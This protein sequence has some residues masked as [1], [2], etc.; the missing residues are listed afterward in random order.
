MRF[1]TP[2]IF[3]GAFLAVAIFAMG[4]L[5]SA[6]SHYLPSGEQHTEANQQSATKSEDKNREPQ[7]L[8]VPTDSVG[9]YTLVLCVFTGVLALVS[10]FQGMMLLRSDKT[11]RIA[12]EATRKSVE[13]AQ[14]EFIASH[15]PQI[16]V[17]NIVVN[18]PRLADGRILP[19]FST[20]HAISGQLF[21]VNVGGSRADILDGHCTVFWTQQ[22]Q[23]PMRR[24]YEGR[25][26]NLNIASRTLLSG[27]STFGPFRSDNVLPAEVFRIAGNE[28]GSWNLY[29]MGWIRYMDRNNDERR[30]SFCSEFRRIGGSE[31]RFYKVD[32]P[33]YER[34][35]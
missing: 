20:G 34:E 25:D 16:R 14:A 24:P 6:S 17:R 18:P 30:T 1:R 26:D 3:L 2:E 32:D 8:W 5:F 12:T 23:L 29:V 21:V 22:G 15:R 31:G 4:M 10:I 11:A 33:D 28:I 35:E 27:Q 9:L 7:S 19:L 13:T